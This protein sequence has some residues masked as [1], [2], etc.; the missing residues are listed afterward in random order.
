MT[1]EELLAEGR[2]RSHQTSPREVADLLRVVD[3]DLADAAVPQI[4]ADR[5]FATAY[6]AALQLATIALHAAGYR[7]AGIG[8]HWTTLHVLAQ[9][10]GTQVQSLTD[11]LDNCRAK[12]NVTDYDRAGE[13][14][15]Q[16]AEEILAEVRIFRRDLLA[17]LRQ[18]Y[19]ALLMTGEKRGVSEEIDDGH[20][21]SQS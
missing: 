16:E 10:M 12:R 19:P 17:W 8:H 2:L 9:I 6:N 20:S 3:R 13:I 14:S 5:R 15:N 4:S 21:Q 7:A 11:Y 1:L 18:N